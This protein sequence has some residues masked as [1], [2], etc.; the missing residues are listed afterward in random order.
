MLLCFVNGFLNLTQSQLLLLIIVS[1]LLIM[2]LAI[3]TKKT[4]L[5]AS[6]IVKSIFGLLCIYLINEG[7]EMVNINLAVGMNVG[8][9]LTVGILG[10]PGFVLLYLLVVYNYYK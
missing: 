2:F 1:C 7:L 4:Q 3:I 8:T 5:V 6:V 10:I 9:G